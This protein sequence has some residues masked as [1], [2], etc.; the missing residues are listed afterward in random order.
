[1]SSE[2][3]MFLFAAVS[4]LGAL[5][6]VAQAFL[7]IFKGPER[8][9]GRKKT[10]IAFGLAIAALIT[11]GLGWY[12]VH[13][14]YAKNP[15]VKYQSAKNLMGAMTAYGVSYPP[16]VGHVF[17][18]VDGDA[19]ISYAEKYKV[20][21][22]VFHDPGTSD[23]R[24]VEISDKSNLFDIAGGDIRIE[25]VLGNKFMSEVSKGYTGTKYAALLVPNKVSMGQ[26]STLREAESV[27]I[28]IIG[29]GFGPP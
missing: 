20:A 22:V 10:R 5:V 29:G 9:S 4:A 28:K 27:G 17:A 23:T 16:Q 3:Y 13:Q 8:T 2:D 25:L 15:Y 18:K 12:Q 26:F 19:I 1:M 21:V 6:S 7:Q 24:D 11:S 14:I